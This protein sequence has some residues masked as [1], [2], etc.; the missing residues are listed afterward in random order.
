MVSLTNGN[1]WW[2][3][4]FGAELSRAVQESSPSTPNECGKIC[5]DLSKLPSYP[6]RI[7]NALK[8][9]RHGKLLTHIHLEHNYHCQSSRLHN[10]KVMNTDIATA[11]DISLQW[12][13]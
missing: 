1:N 12:L 7:E 5:D 8:A 2:G 13:I 3:K 10:Y 4:I 9:Q 11:I 6:D